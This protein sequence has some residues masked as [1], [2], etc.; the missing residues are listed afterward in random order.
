MFEKNINI[1][2]NIL[3]KNK[4]PL[5]YKEPS[6]LDIFG[7]VNDK[8]IQKNKKELEERVIREAE[9]ENKIKSIQREKLN[10]MKMILGVSDSVNNENKIENI[11]LLDEYKKKIELLNEEMDELTFELETIPKE[12]REINLSLLN[13]SIQY[14]YS[15]LKSKEKRLSN[16]IEEIQI[17]RDRLKTLIEEK[18][19]E[20]EW[21]NKTYTFF[22]GLLGSEIIEEIDRERLK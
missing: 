5:L 6:W 15:E 16:S 3:R 11:V 20:E 12:I 4:I 17:L 8:E 14:G 13:A 1:D 21:I 19:N 7:D 18:H 10:C 2:I 9:I 22:H